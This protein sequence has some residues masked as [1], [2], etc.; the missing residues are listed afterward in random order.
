MKTQR[1]KT[2]ETTGAG[3]KSTETLAQSPKIM[4]QRQTIGEIN[5]MTKM[6]RTGAMIKIMAMRKKI[7]LINCGFWAVCLY[8]WNVEFYI[9]FGMCVESCL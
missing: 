6:R 4:P 7:R 8:A 3:R 9:N 2:R 1:T 5:Q